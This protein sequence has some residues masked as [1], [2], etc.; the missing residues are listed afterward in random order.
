MGIVTARHAGSSR[1]RDRTGVPCT[2][3][4]ILNHWATREA[5]FILSFIWLHWVLVGTSQVALVVKETICQCGRHKRHGFDPWVRKT[6]LEEGMTTHSAIL[7]WRIPWT[8][9]PGGL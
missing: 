3:K 2:A 7:A 9:E 5:L 8:E 1:T 4:Q 6:P